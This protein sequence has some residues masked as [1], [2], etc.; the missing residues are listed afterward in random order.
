MKVIS[1]TDRVVLGVVSALLIKRSLTKTVELIFWV[2]ILLS[3]FR[4]IF[5]PLARLNSAIALTIEKLSNAVE[6][7]SIAKVKL[8]LISPASILLPASRF[9]FPPLPTCK[10]AKGAAKPIL[11]SSMVSTSVTRL[12]LIPEAVLKLPVVIFSAANKQ[13][14]LHSLM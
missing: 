5:P 8:E 2:V 4:R 11:A 13:H 7:L 12:R 6:V 14:S 1:E 9:I 3:A 10:F